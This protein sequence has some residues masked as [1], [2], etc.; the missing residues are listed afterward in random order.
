MLSC[1]IL[2]VECTA[3]DAEKLSVSQMSSPIERQIPGHA[4]AIR[5]ISFQRPSQCAVMHV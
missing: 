3:A 1:P 4:P 2:F 5:T